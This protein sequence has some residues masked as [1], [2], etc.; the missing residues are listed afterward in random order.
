MGVYHYF[1]FL[2]YLVSFI[3]LWKNRNVLSKRNQIPIS[4][5]AYS[6]ESG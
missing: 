3:S 5:A 2:F 4:E 6:C 1:I